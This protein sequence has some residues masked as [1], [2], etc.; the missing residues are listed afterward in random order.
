MHNPL[1]GTV[2]LFDPAFPG[3]RWKF[4]NAIEF[5][6]PAATVLGA[7]GFL[8]V[9]DFDPIANPA[10]LAEFRRQHAIP[11]A[12]QILGP[13]KGKLGNEGDS[14]ELYKPDPPQQPPHPDAGFV[15]SILVEGILYSAALPWP[16]EAADPTRSLQRRSVLGFGNE[17]R[18]WVAAAPTP[19]KS[20]QIVV[21]LDADKD[22]IPDEWERA[23]GLNPAEASDAA[24]DGDGDGMTN[25]QEFLAG[26]DPSIRGSALRLSWA[27]NANGA[28]SVEFTAQ[29]EKSYSIERRD[30]AGTGTWEV[31]SAVESS[32]QARVVLLD[33]RQAGFYRVVTPKR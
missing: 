29:P 1:S 13:F 25:L 10:L 9:V 12:T 2:A 22:G 14:V 23:H 33:I 28:L 26:T 31:S 18:N 32:G 16:V 4:A 30:A 5:E 11:T 8:L 24:L 17:P 21:A 7:G 15:P 19:G 3:N 27:F 6:F 20:T